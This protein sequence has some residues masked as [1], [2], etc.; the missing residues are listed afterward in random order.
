MTRN[1]NFFVVAAQFLLSLLFLSAFAYAGSYQQTNLV[2]DIPGLAAL[3]DPNLVNS[4][5]VTFSP[6]GPVWVAD[7]GTGVSPNHYRNGSPSARPSSPPVL[8]VPPPTAIT[9]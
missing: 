8:T 7:N 9:D 3:T 5:G 1:R 2:S 4:W 6:T